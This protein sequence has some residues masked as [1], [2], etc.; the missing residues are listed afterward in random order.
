[1]KQRHFTKIVSTLG[2]ASSAPETIKALAEAGVNVFRLNFSHGSHD[3]HRKNVAS[4]RQAEKEIGRPLAILCD[5]QGPKLR[6]G[7]FKDD[8]HIELHAGDKFRLD[9]PKRA[10]KRA[11]VCRIPK[12]SKPW[13]KAWI[14]C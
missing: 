3:A 9:P 4:I 12:S 8:K 14:C 7:T 6:I 10:M 1:M 5:M 13:K 11:F 2:P